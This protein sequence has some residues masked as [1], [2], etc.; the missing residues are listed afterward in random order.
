M[1]FLE[2]P[3]ELADSIADLVGVYGA[4]GEND[5]CPDDPRKTCRICFVSKI[6]SRIRGSVENERLLEAAGRS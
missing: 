5:E 1:P 3:D 2:N 6:A 4:H